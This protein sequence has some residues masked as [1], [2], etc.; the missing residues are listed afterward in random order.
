LNPYGICLLV[1][2]AMLVAH[3]YVSSEMV[4][5]DEP[6]EKAVGVWCVWLLFASL[7]FVLF[8][9]KWLREM[10][11]VT[12]GALHINDSNATVA[13]IQF[14]DSSELFPW[15]SSGPVKILKDEGTISLQT[16]DDGIEIS[17]IVRDRY[18]REVVRVEKNHWFVRAQ[19]SVDHN[20]TDTALEVLDS[21]G[22]VVLQL[23]L[24]PDRIQIH[25]ERHDAFG[26]GFQIVDS[27]PDPNN[28][29]RFIKC[30]QLFGTGLLEREHRLMIPPMFKYPSSRHWGEFARP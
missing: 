10:S 25:G 23:R 16:G 24:F 26:G 9:S 5:N 6:L 19:N 21:G 14:G 29:G 12:E 13:M 2:A 7:S 3:M 22:H 27:C 20:Y 4:E 8:Q 1:I 28:A 18:D 30:L 15:R 11:E 17:T